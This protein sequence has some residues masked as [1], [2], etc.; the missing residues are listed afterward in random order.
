[1]SK[2][3]TSEVRLNG[4]IG[5]AVEWIR[6][7]ASLLLLPML[8]VLVWEGGGDGVGIGLERCIVELQRRHDRL[9]GLTFV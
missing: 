4:R 3:D 2:D 7:G 6:W 8:G 5:R 1:M 9:N